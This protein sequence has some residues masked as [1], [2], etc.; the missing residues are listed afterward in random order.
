M[1]PGPIFRSSW[2]RPRASSGNYAIAI[3]GT[4]GDPH[5]GW[6]ITG[7]L[8]AVNVK[9]A[10]ERLSV[11]PGFYGGNPRVVQTGPC[12]GFAVLA[13]ETRL[14]LE[15]MRSLSPAQ[16]ASARIAGERPE[17]VI[18]GPGRRG[19]LEKFEGLQAKH[20]TSAQ[21]G[22]LQLLVGEYVRNAKA[23]SAAEQ[24]DAIGRSGWDNVWFSRR[25]PTDGS[26]EFYYRVY[27][28]RALNAEQHP[29]YDEYMGNPR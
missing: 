6:K 20:M 19:S 1:P 14:S 13:F 25:G 4:P 8:L 3:F 15:L 11:L 10:G 16:Q 26:G 2:H 7:H 5:W 28:P 22:H 17:D 18:E 27:D 21:L 12:A 9:V 29:S 23:A 24:L